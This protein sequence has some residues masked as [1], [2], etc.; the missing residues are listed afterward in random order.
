M[1]NATTASAETRPIANLGSQ[2]EIAPPIAPKAV[3]TGRSR[4]VAVHTGPSIVACWPAAAAS[5]PTV[6]AT[7]ISNAPSASLDRALQD[8]P[9]A[10]D[11]LRKGQLETAASVLTGP[12]RGLD[13]RVAGDD[14]THQAAPGR[15]DQGGEGRHAG[16]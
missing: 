4:K 10:R 8:H 14:E 9:R 13:D 7:A 2:A 5:S 6:P 16:L 15:G 1:K 12:A 3:A 11:R